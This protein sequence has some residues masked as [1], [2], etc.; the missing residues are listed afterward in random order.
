MPL[1]GFAVTSICGAEFSSASG[2]SG[3]GNPLGLL[4]D[5]LASAIS[6]KDPFAFPFTIH[7]KTELACD[8]NRSRREPE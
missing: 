4:S 1:E 8:T 2:E 5:A 3:L 7:P 6:C